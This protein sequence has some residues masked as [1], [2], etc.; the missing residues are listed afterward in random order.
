MTGSA[1][2]TTLGCPR[3]GA[4][5]T[6]AD[7]FGTE[8]SQRAFVRLAEVSVPLGAR[9]TSYVGL[10]APP[11]TRLTIAKQAKHILALLPDLERRAI[12]H[13]GRD[14]PAPLDVW[15]AAI[16]HMLFLRDQGRLELP[17]ASHA[18]LY[19]VM[20][21]MANKHEARQ[22]AE[23]ETERAQRRTTQHTVQVNGQT[24]S[25]GDALQ[26]VHG[27]RDPALV[28]IERHQKNAAPMPAAVREQLASLRR[29][30]TTKE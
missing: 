15:A 25:I 7:I 8:E 18:Y 26:Q 30:P 2:P 21:G 16:D 12:T 13:A 17:M 1:S 28:Q 10:F 5:V 9:V 24:L 29:P 22:E 11:R 3:C 19:K 14:W 4:E 23:R 27:G 6:P 20:A